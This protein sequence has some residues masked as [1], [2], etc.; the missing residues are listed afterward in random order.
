MKHA[1]VLGTAL[2]VAAG[3][4]TEKPKDAAPD[5]GVPEPAPGRPANGVAAA[6][7]AGYASLAAVAFAPL[8]AAQRARRD[9]V[10]GEGPPAYGLHD[11]IFMRRAVIDLGDIRADDTR[12]VFVSCTWEDALGGQVL[13]TR[14][15][16][17]KVADDGERRFEWVGPPREVTP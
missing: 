13:E 5:W 16:V 11:A 10:R 8:A 1:W 6:R 3:C 4:T 17:V 15:G 7:H 12:S 9:A 2:V 14:A